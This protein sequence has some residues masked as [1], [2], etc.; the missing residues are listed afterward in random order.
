MHSHLHEL[1]VPGIAAGADGGRVGD[2]QGKL[3]DT[4]NERF[5]LSRLN[6]SSKLLPPQHHPQLLKV[7]AETSVIASLQARSTARPGVDFSR[8]RRLTYTFVSMTIRC[9]IPHRPRVV[10]AVRRPYPKTRHTG[11]SP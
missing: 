1:V 11:W 2:V 5:D 7:A 10:Q 8:I 3:P 9:F 6:I 4:R